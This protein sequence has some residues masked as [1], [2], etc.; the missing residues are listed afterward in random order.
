MDIMQLVCNLYILYVTL[1]T[2]LMTGMWVAHS[3]EQNPA[4]LK[5]LE[6]FQGGV[7]NTDL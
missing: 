5:G 6:G 7:K 4:R 1:Y 3:W 2:I